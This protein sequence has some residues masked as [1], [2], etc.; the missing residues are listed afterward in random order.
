HQMSLH[1]WVLE[2]TIHFPKLSISGTIDLKSVLTSLGIT[3]VFSHEADLSGIT[4]DAPLRVSQALHKAVLTI[5]ER[6]TEDEG[7]T[8]KGPM[9]LTLAPQVKFNSPFLVII[10]EHSTRSPLFVGKVVNPTQ[11]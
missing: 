10:Y 9:A 3:K 4:E 11:Q 1:P 6:G 7:D 5:D 2:V 8:V